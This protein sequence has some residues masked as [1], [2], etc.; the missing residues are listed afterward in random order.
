MQIPFQ[1]ITK[2]IWST[3]QQNIFDLDPIFQFKYF[4]N[5]NVTVVKSQVIE[6]ICYIRRNV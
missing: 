5:N 2:E 6:Y 3:E 1:P 4:A